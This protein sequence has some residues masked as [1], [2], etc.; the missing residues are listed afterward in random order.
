MSCTMKLSTALI[1]CGLACGNLL[2]A[3]AWASGI[4]L[5]DRL[6]GTWDVTYELYDKDGTMRPYHGQVTY[7]RILN[8]A[9]LQEIWTS[10]IHNKIPQPYGT[11]IG[12]ADSTGSRWTAIWMFPAKAYIGIVRGG[13]TDDGIVLTGKDDDGTLQRWTIDHIETDSFLFHFESS[14]D[15][16]KT[17]RLVGLNRMHR[18]AARDCL[19][20]LARGSRGSSR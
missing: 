9:A 4:P 19:R 18:H 16:G 7:S 20:R 3:A 11:T 6:S 10:D 17:W 5:Y 15:D 8:G 14:K 13:L 1:A 12:F 2:G